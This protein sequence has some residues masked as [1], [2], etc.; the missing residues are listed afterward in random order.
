MIGSTRTREEFD[1]ERIQKIGLLPGIR[2]LQQYDEKVFA[3]LLEAKGFV[4]RF[5]TLNPS[6]DY[7]R[8]LHRMVF[9]EVHPWAGEIRQPGR[10]P[11]RVG[12]FVTCE[13]ERLAIELKMLESQTAELLAKADRQGTLRVIAFH[14]ARFES[15]HPFLDGNGRVGRLLVESQL[16][17]SPYGVRERA[18]VPRQEYGDA[19]RTSNR[20]SQS[21][22]PGQPAQE[23]RGSCSAQPEGDGSTVPLGTAIRRDDRA[24]P[25]HGAGS[26]AFTT[27]GGRSPASEPLGELT[28]PPPENRRH[29][30]R[31]KAVSDALQA[32]LVL[33]DAY[34]FVPLLLH[35]DMPLHGLPCI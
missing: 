13:A 11:P 10:L 20:I 3:A 35:L 18:E 16:N 19:L 5:P 33:P 14:H 7:M 21:A 22:A 31:H 32:L 6:V 12:G 15:L 29:G 9:H 34:P 23:T 28:R 25:D 2:T 27:L 26:R 4:Q 17:A 30:S 1:W 8:I 24:I